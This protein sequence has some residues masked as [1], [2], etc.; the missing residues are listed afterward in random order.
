MINDTLVA[1]IM[2]PKPH[3]GPPL[4]KLAVLALC[5]IFFTWLLWPSDGRIRHCHNL[6]GPRGIPVFGSLFEIRKGHAKTFK[7]WAERYGG[8]FRV[9]LGNKEVVVLNTREAVAKTLVKQ[10]A[11]YQ[12]RPEWEGL[13]HEAPVPDDA[14]NGVSTIGTTQWGTGLAK[15]RKL[16]IPHTKAHKLPQY[17][18]FSSK[19]YLRM[20]QMLTEAESKP[21]DLGFCW[22]STAMGI[23]TDQLVGQSH[24]EKF[25]RQLCETEMNLVRLRA[26]GYPLSDWVPLLRVSQLAMGK[27]KFQL[28]TLLKNAS[29][30]VPVF[31][32]DAEQKRIETLIS[33]QE[34]YCKAQLSSLLERISKGDTT[35]SQVGDLFRAA[36]EPLSERDQYQLVYTLSGA[37]MPI[38]TILTWLIGYMASHPELQDKAFRA[39]EEVYN[40]EVP[41]P[42]DTDR[43]EY[44]KALAT[45]AGRYWTI[46][47]LGLLRQTHNDSR[48]DDAFIPQGTVVVFNS[49]EINRDAVAYDSPDKFMPERWIDGHQGR[50][51]VTGIAG[52]KIG[53]PHMSHGTGRRFCPGFASVNKSLY[54]TLS[55]ALH[56]FKFERAEL[57]DEGM[58]E[59]FPSFRACRQTT[60]D[61]DPVYDQVD[62]CDRQ[63]V[64]CATGIH[65]VPR[66]REQLNHWLTEGHQ[67]MQDFM[68]P[69]A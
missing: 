47:R 52:D 22:W 40:G 18:H 46:V 25:T 54:G 41:D 66:N 48:L 45:E 14:S 39:M 31:L 58:K 60:A 17:N 2:L 23:V 15:L 57:D 53:V 9:V 19:R 29:L 55:L 28:R 43:V 50:T 24:D 4:Y 59:V 10:G 36:S 62:A 44:I 68:V 13:S 7:A 42:H 5:I 3:T 20:V 37:G 27:L 67:S 12:A 38:G 1:S 69:W 49:F 63:S 8:V 33:T 34:K 64:P 35:P 6:P 26:L 65:A 11:N 32:A 21:K 56:F 51:D 16:L 61:M 30:S